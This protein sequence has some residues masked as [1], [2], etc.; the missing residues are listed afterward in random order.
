MLYG[1]IGAFE[2]RNCEKTT[3]NE[4]EKSALS[5]RQCTVLQVDRYNGKIAWIA[6]W[7]VSPSTVFFGS[8][9]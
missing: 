5:L 4:E 2:G 6:L 9:F 3:P 8:G 7:I 1:A